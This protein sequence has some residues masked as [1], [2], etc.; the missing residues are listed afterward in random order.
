MNLAEVKD[1]PRAVMYEEM[2]RDLFKNMGARSTNA[3]HASLGITGEV[4]ELI[5]ALILKD[6]DNLV[7]ESGD[8]FFY[9]QAMLNLFNWSFVE[10]GEE[11]VKIPGHLFMVFRHEPHAAMVYY[12]SNIADELKKEWAYNKELNVDSLKAN[13]SSF[14]AMFMFF[15]KER[16]LDMSDVM[17]HNQYKLVTGPKARYP[18]GKYTDAAAIARADKIG[19]AVEQDFNKAS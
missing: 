13:V 18:S 19:E 16:G 15:L 9:V 7:E 17:A 2:V 10:L 6:F 12:A 11:G 14:C 4:G 1:L 3:I 5:P 8:T